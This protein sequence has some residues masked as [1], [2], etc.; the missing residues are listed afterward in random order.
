MKGQDLRKRLL[1][2]V[3]EDTRSFNAIMAAF[4]L[5]KD[6]NTEKAERKK[7]IQE[8]TK[9]A[10]E[11]PFRVMELSLESLRITKSM[12]ELGNPNS[13]TDAGV[14]ALCARTALSGAFMNV[15]INCSSYDDKAFTES[16][17]KKGV[18]LEKEALEL[19]K[20]VLE[21]ISKAIG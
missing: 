19:E 13:I 17:I 3:D 12:A 8:A 15:K 10:I 7:A 4:Q 1:D 20:T 18:A 14:G 2:M 6:S 21:L 9:Y 11:I 16:I 5:P